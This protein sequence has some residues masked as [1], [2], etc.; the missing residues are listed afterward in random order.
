MTF[1]EAREIVINEHS[2][3]QVRD[4]L[5]AIM[6]EIKPEAVEADNAQS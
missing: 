5:L 6:S 2:P 1:E 3:G 4:I